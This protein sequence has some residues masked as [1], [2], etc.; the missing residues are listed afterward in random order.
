MVINH[1]DFDDSLRYPEFKSTLS[2]QTYAYATSFYEP[3]VVIEFLR[4]DGKIYRSTNAGANQQQAN[5]RIVSAQ[6][7]T[8]GDEKRLKVRMR[9]SCR[10]YNP[11]DPNDAMNIETGELVTFFALFY[12]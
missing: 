1:A 4:S 2:P 8:V 12:S 3:G 9:F 10:L 6:E 11:D 7:F 5:F